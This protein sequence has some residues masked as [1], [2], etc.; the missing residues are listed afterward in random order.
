MPNASFAALA[1]AAGDEHAFAHF[2]LNDA[3]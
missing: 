1:C 2:N 3:I